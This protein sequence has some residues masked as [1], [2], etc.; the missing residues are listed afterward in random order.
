MLAAEIANKYTE[1]FV[2]EQQNSNHAYYAS[3][4]KLVEKQLNTLTAEARRSALRGSR[5]RV[6]RNRSACS[7]N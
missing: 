5:C 3:A 6:A 7:P 4:L 1:E 2:Y